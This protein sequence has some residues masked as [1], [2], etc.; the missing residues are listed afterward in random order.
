MQRLRKGPVSSVAADRVKRQAARRDDEETAA[1]LASPGNLE[2]V[3]AGEKDVRA[4]D[5]VPASVILA[6]WAAAR[7]RGQSAGR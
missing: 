5:V 1:F 3:R 7:D 2:R 6:Q 4:G